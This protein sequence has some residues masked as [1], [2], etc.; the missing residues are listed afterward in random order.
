VT[1]APERVALVTGVS[2]RRGIGFAVAR[3]LLADGAYVVIHSWTAHDAEQPWGADPDGVAAVLEELGGIGPRL[4]HVEADLADPAS[5]AAVVA[6]AV[7]SFGAID[8]LVVNHARSSATTLETVTAEELDRSWAVNA[9]AVV[10]LVQAYAAQR[11]HA[12]GDG[13][14]VLFTSGQHLAPMTGELAYAVTKGAVH[15]MTR[16]LADALADRGVTLNAINPGPVDTGW[17]SDDLREQLRPQF[18]RGHWGRPE[19][20]AA[21][22]AW[23][24]SADSGQITGQVIDAEAGFRRHAP[25]P[26]PG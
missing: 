15:Q 10:L 12:R 3:R 22:V 21:V 16:S 8:V 26:Q 19:D 24:A 20:I 17:P 2:R 23:L 7:R 4:D 6:H 18:P 14:V 5:P 9:R 11:D 25:P 13:R 1:I